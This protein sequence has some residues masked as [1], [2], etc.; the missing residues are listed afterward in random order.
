M[1]RQKTHR[2]FILLIPFICYIYLIAA[3]LASGLLKK[4]L[5][6]AIGFVL[7][8]MVAI[9]FTVLLIYIYKVINKK[10]SNGFN[11]DLKLN[12]KEKNILFVLALMIPL[13]F[14][15]SQQTS[16]LIYTK[17]MGKEYLPIAYTVD[18]MKDDMSMFIHAVIIAPILEELCFRIIPISMCRNKTGK[19]FMLIFTSI[20]FGYSHGRSFWTSL[21]DGTVFGLILLFTNRPII[22]IACHMIH[23]LFSFIAALLIYT[24]F[25]KFY[26]CSDYPTLVV[27][28][29]P[30][31]IVVSIV[32][33]SFISIMYTVN[34]KRIG[35]KEIIKEG[36]I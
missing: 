17:V 1:K 32:L 3:D 18:E 24:G 22:S 28:D 20:L 6:G 10:Y 36:G 23:N 16:Y 15:I 2:M 8:N 7:S 26:S 30:L 31:L 25:I 9:I 21:I 27:F 35:S 12:E 33:I 34:K 4:N 11:I 5:P 14:M 29:V 19:I 13:L